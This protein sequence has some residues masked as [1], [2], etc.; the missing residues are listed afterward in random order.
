MDY[1]FVCVMVL[2]VVAT[3]SWA[4]NREKE[5][6]TNLTVTYTRDKHVP[7]SYFLSLSLSSIDS[8]IVQPIHSFIHS[9]SHDTS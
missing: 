1:V 8:K 6:V 2:M 5:I 7:H 3:I 4:P 9:T